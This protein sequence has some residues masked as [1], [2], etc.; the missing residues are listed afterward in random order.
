MLDAIDSTR[1]EG[2]FCGGLSHVPEGQARAMQ[3]LDDSYGKCP[4]M[5]RLGKSPETQA[6]IS[7]RVDMRDNKYVQR[8][9]C[10]LCMDDCA[11]R[12]LECNSLSRYKRR[13]DFAAKTVS[14]SSPWYVSD[15]AEDCIRTAGDMDPAVQ[16]V[17]DSLAETRSE[18][19][20]ICHGPH[21][22]EDL[23]PFQVRI[24]VGHKI[25]TGG[26]IRARQSTL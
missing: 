7:M 4:V 6:V 17:V 2:I 26:L 21:T 19:E 15:L 11:E 3:L 14:A 8:L 22:A 13:R 1:V 5:L 25:S 16:A 20:A 18:L 23:I 12:C 10:T 24:A 9:V